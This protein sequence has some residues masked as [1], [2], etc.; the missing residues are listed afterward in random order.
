MF[1]NMMKIRQAIASCPLP[2]L[3]SAIIAEIESLRLHDR[4]KPGQSVA[5]GCSSRGIANYGL[6]IATLVKSLQAKGL[7]PFL[8]PAMGSHGAATA[9][10]QKRV[11]E[12]HGITEDELGV[13]IK[14]SLDTVKIGQLDN[15]TPVLIDQFAFEADHIVIV[16]RVKSHTEFTHA[17]ES[18]LMKMLAIGMG[19]EQGATLYH[20]AFMIE[21]YAAIIER[22]AATVF[23]TGKFLF[24]LGIVEDGLLQ[25]AKIAA[26]PAEKLLEGEI[27]LL[28]LAK[29]LEPKLPF[30]DVDVLIIDEMGKDISGSGFDAK[31]V[32][33][34]NMPLVSPEPEAPR[35]KRIVVRDLT[36]V[37]NGNADGV[38]SADFITRKLYEK[39]DMNSLYVNALA[40]SEPEHARIPMV[41]ESTRAAVEAGMN[42]IGLIEE[43]EIKV[44]RIRNTKEVSV[45]EVSTA[46]RDQMKS[47]SDIEVVGTPKPFNFD[48]QGELEMLSVNDK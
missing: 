11:I 31:V 48:E 40:G 22:V 15:G 5:V 21:G 37:S 32:G 44:M 26:F 34:I 23:N 3:E 17:F 1:P 10:G 13:P 12:S 42:T 20:K 27:D 25:T 4:V 9:M 43:D 7:K 24:G 28:R 29:K 16:N 46:Y 19:K 2:D 39:I 33:R 47:R 18:G 38:G 45:V 8:F 35:I 36:D 6:I 14:S 41:M 30:E